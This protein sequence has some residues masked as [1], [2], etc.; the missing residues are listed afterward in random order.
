[1]Q[2][3]LAM[4]VAAAAARHEAHEPTR[5]IAKTAEKQRSASVARAQERTAH[6]ALSDSAGCSRLARMAAAA[7]AMAQCR[8]A[9]AACP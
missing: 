1:M 3:T 4:R 2:N 7:A 8:T 6:V 9:A 5:D